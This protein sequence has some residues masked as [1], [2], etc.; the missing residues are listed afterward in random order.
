MQ[1]SVPA[2]LTKDK[3]RLR[4]EEIAVH[5]AWKS[6]LYVTNFPESADD[7]VV[8]DL[9]GQVTW[10]VT[11][12]AQ[13]VDDFLFLQYGLIFDVRWPSKKFKNTRR[14]C[15]VQYA[16]PVSSTSS[17]TFEQR[18]FIDYPA[19]VGRKSFGASRARIGG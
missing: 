14:F 11:G 2:A 3:K 13:G 9:F 10:Y 18:E 16:S 17:V 1:D 8:R 5:L 7:A 19:V 12:M 15:Y 4:G 6:T